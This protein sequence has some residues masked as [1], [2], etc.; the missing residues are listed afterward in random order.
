MS[1]I[2]IAPI[3][4]GLSHPLDGVVGWVTIGKAI[5]HDQVEDIVRGE[6]LS[7]SLLSLPLQ[8]RVTDD[9]L[10]ALCPPYPYSEIL[11]HG[12]AEVQIEETVA[13]VGRANRLG[14]RDT[15]ALHGE[16]RPDQLVSVEEDLESR[17]LHPHPPLLWVDRDPALRS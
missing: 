7:L 12:T 3:D 14:E 9:P 4:K 1:G 10:V 17:I 8:E 15:D 13:R 5:R 6:A 16:R 11:G 2:A